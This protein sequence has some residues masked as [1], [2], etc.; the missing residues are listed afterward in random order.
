MKRA[1]TDIF[2]GEKFYGR[3]EV[4]ADA[5]V[6]HLDQSDFDTV[7]DAPEAPAIPEVG[8]PAE[9]A[10]EAPKKRGKKKAA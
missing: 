2:C 3:G 8:A 9:E 6:A 10:A 7:A 5:D 1:K 4:F